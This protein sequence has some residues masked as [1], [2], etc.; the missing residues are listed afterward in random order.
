MARPPQWTPRNLCCVVGLGEPLEAQTLA[1][2]KANR[3]PLTQDEL[4]RDEGIGWQIIA[5]V[6][7]LLPDVR[8]MDHLGYGYGGVSVEYLGKR[9]IIGLWGVDRFG[10]HTPARIEMAAGAV[11]ALRYWMDEVRK[12]QTKVD[13]RLLFDML[14]PHLRAFYAAE[15]RLCGFR[16]PSNDLDKSGMRVSHALPGFLQTSDIIRQS[17]NTIREIFEAH[18]TEAYG[19]PMTSDEHRTVVD[20]LSHER[21][22][23]LQQGRT[24]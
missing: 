11:P 5:E 10:H 6:K 2:R 7:R 13:V 4:M 14:E 18:T 16:N 20:G 24:I 22:L 8:V 3:S 17:R 12:A 23:A 1:K 15:Q 9:H 21:S 19:R